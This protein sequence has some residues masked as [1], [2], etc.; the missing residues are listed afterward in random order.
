MFD[1]VFNAATY[2]IFGVLG[3]F[4]ITLFHAVGFLPTE[5]LL[6]LTHLSVFAMVAGFAIS[7]FQ[8][9]NK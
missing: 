8:R 1:F 6:N 4:A 7:G 2:F 9:A 3:Y 5:T